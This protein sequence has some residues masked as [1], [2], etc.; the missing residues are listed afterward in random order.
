MVQTNAA[1]HG[2]LLKR[3]DY[4]TIFSEQLKG[5]RD[6]AIKWIEY[7]WTWFECIE[8]VYVVQSRPN[9][10]TLAQFPP[11]L[12]SVI[13]DRFKR[14]GSKLCVRGPLHE[15]FWRWRWYQQNKDTCW[16]RKR[17]LLRMGSMFSNLPPH[18]MCVDLAGK[19]SLHVYLFGA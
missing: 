18:D 2:S 19:K 15:L 11:L 3:C 17:Q 16:R 1:K 10:R 12:N 13:G 9:W 14:R 8:P 7:P 6:Y 4:L 5:T